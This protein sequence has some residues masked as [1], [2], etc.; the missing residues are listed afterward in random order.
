[1]KNYTYA[2]RNIY[3]IFLLLLPSLSWSQSQ[4]KMSSFVRKAVREYHYS[5]KGGRRNARMGDEAVP[6][7]T[8]FVRTSDV[9]VL[10]NCGCSIYANWDD[11]YI[12]EIPLDKMAYLC[13][14]SS[15]RRI[16]AGRSCAVTNENS[17][18]ITNVRDVWNISAPLPVTGKGIIVGVMDIGFDLTHPNWYSADMREY[19]IRQVWDMLDN[20]ENGVAVVGK[21]D[22]GADTIF[23]GRQYIGTDAILAKRHTADALTQYHGTHTMG[24]AAGSGCEGDGVS[25]YVGMAPEAELCVVSNYTT[26]DQDIIPEKDR[27]K[28]TTA[29]DILGF[30]YIFDYA[31]S[32][33]KPC[34]INFSEGA[35]DEL[36]ESAIYKEVLS[37]MLGP[38]RILCAAAGNNGNLGTYLHKSGGEESKGAFIRSSSKDASFVMRSEKPVQIQLT[39]YKDNERRLDWDYDLTRLVSYPDSVMHDTLKVGNDV[40]AISLSTYPSCYDDKLLATDLCVSDVAN[41]TFGKNTIVSLVVTGSNNDIEVISAGGSF[42]KNNLDNSLCDFDN[43][44]NVFFPS[45]AEDVICVG[46]SAHVTTVESHTGAIYGDNLGTNGVRAPFSSVGP[47]INGCVKPDVMTPGVNIIS[48]VNSYRTD[49]RNEEKYGSRVFEYEGRKHYWALAKG[50]SMACPVVSGIIALWLQVCPT[51]TPEMIKDVFAHS[52]SHYDESMSYPNNYYGWGNVDALAGIE[53]IQQNYTGIKEESYKTHS[54]AIYNINGIKVSDAKQPGLYIIS[55][56][57]GVRKL[58][59]AP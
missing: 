10:R 22:S 40:F 34:V 33:G 7:M 45:S 32:V 38:G 37:K 3:L 50:T 47:A 8:A 27:Y 21:T 36:Q 55:D 31:Q 56:G 18:S 15:V 49:L 19:R 39:F 54:V 30:K 51:L 44:H 20:S 43:T 4:D 17:A 16:E 2:F 24:T 58:R 12:A 23:V 29:T 25:Q 6:R 1:M 35:F 59:I 42:V 52:C 11:I 13:S 48:S 9:Q 57:N 53:Y 41:T 5:Q 14:H 26:E 46:A 28:Y